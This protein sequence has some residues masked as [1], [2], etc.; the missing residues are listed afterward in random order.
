MVLSRPSSSAQRANPRSLRTVWDA[1]FEAVAKLYVRDG[2]HFGQLVKSV[3]EGRKP[4]KEGYRPAKVVTCKEYVIFG[5][6]THAGI[7]TSRIE[8]QNWTLR[9]HVRRLTRLSNGF[10]RKLENLVAAIALHFAAYNFT[11]KH[12]TLGMTPAMAAGIAA[13]QW[14][15]GDL[16]P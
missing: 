12:V 3:K 16:V 6:P 10:S 13:H 14:S 8:R 7:S 11:K 5:D 9:T 15:I 1:Y 2:A 4:V